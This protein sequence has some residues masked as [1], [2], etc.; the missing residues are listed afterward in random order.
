MGSSSSRGQILTAQF[1]ALSCLLREDV[2]YHVDAPIDRCNHNPENQ[3]S[4]ARMHDS[5]M[6]VG[7]HE[8]FKYAHAFIPAICVRIPSTSSCMTS[9]NLCTWSIHP[10]LHQSHNSASTK[11]RN[12]GNGC[13]F[14]PSSP[15]PERHQRLYADGGAEQAHDS[16]QHRHS[17]LRDP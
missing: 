1:F 16:R 7:A 15:A 2:H 9:W 6:D 3:N 10:P 11:H 13:P 5:T 4:H 12:I 17:P 14:F 8:L